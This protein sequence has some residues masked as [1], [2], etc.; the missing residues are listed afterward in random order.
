MN[1]E[2][3]VAIHT[4]YLLSFKMA[5]YSSMLVLNNLAESCFKPKLLLQNQRLA[6]LRVPL[7]ICTLTFITEMLQLVTIAR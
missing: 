7:Q 5:L 1:S 2:N 6:F 3:C 4:N